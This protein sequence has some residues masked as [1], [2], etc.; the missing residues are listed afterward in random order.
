M[1]ETPGQEPLPWLERLD[2]LLRSAP[3]K[4]GLYLF[5][6][7]MAVRVLYLSQYA[8]TPFFWV[9]QMDAL[10]HDLA[11]QAVAAGKASHEPFFRAPLYYYFLGGVYRLFG[12]SYWA[13]RLAQALIGSGSCVLLYALGGRMFRPTVALLAAAAMA[14]YGPLVYFDGELHT[15][16]LEVFLDLAFLLALVRARESA[17]WKGW[18]AAGLLLGLS[19]I[20]RP[21]VLVAAPLALA[22][23][24]TAPAFHT[25]IPGGKLR[26][27][28]VAAFLAAT[29]LA[30][31]L[32]TL[33]NSLVSGDR[34]FIASQ[35]GINLYLGNRPEADGF[36]PSTPTRYRF[37]TA[38]EDSV[39][40]Y[41]RKAAEEALGRPLKPSEAQRYWIGR[42]LDWW[43]R[44]P[45]AAL[46]LTA[47]KW[48]LA[49]GS[50][51][52]RNNT[53]FD[54]IRAE[55]APYLW[56]APFGFWFAGGFGLLGMLLAWRARPES[57]LLSGFALLYTA[58]FVLFFVADRFRLPVVPVLLLF[59]A[60]AVVTLAE[61]LRAPSR[62]GLASTLA[63]AAVCL[64]A[65]NVEWVRT[66]TPATYAL[67]HWSAGN[68]YRQM[69]RFPEAEAQYRKAL[70]LDANNAEIWTNLGAAQYY[71][72]RP[73][74]AEASFQRSIR[75]DP[76]NGS[77]YYNLAMCE[78]QLGRRQNGRKLLEEAVR[79]DPEH[80]G[81]R[82]E[83]V[84]LAQGA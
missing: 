50:R 76:Q 56:L 53:S 52:I 36:T 54:F 15:P 6:A 30:P 78:L 79:R 42:V 25:A 22:W 3:V 41:G 62:R 69:G 39:A 58:S 74:E 75:L 59:A 5:I 68:R 34:I 66:A 81:A 8:T 83:L 67:D 13:A 27:A 16:V 44:H 31:G 65:V 35:G 60:Y 20:T 21:N 17:A 48:V 12:H 46:Q 77:G 10:Y 23:L 49:W 2:A 73:E 38:Y 51:E 7:A 43:A 9:P 19:A 32:A 29:A 26:P 18:L 84:K 14:L 61:Q 55:F 63:L 72:G 82:A 4:T 45:A 47:K 11:A 57:R 64:L 40:L 37:D 28:A 80:A 33:R 70:A 71:S 24:W 1:T